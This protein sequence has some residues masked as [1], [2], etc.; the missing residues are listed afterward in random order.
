MFFPPELNTHFSK[1]VLGIV[2]NHETLCIPNSN[3][4][5]KLLYLYNQLSDIFCKY[6]IFTGKSGKSHKAKNSKKQPDSDNTATKQPDSAK[7]KSSFHIPRINP[8]LT[9]DSDDDSI[10]QEPSHFNNSA[11]KF[12]LESNPMVS[13]MLKS[14]KLL[15]PEFHSLCNDFENLML[16]S[17]TKQTWAKHCSAWKLFIEFCNAY[18]VLFE[19]PV[20]K[21]YIRAFVAWATTKKNLKSSTVKAYISSINIAHALGNVDCPNLN[22]DWCTKLALK[23]A[24][25]FSDLT[26]VHRATRLPMNIDLLTLLGHRIKNLEW[27]A[28]AKQVFWTACLTSFFS[29]CRMGE[30][31]APLENSFEPGITLTWENVVFSGKGEVLIFIPFCKTT[32]FNGNLI[33]LYTV[34]NCKFC[35]IASLNRLKRMAIAEDVWKPKNPI[36]AFK[37]G[38]FLTKQKVNLWLSKILSDFTDENHTFTGHSFRAAIPSILASHPDKCRVENIKDWGGWSSD[39]YTVYAKSDREKRRVLFAEIMKCVFPE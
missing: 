2:M 8:I 34:E 33:D 29:S 28:Y 38:K 7:K 4:P 18:G 11:A 32:G 25:N 27:G 26:T 24:K 13:S 37:N 20:N 35:P 22:S 21:E 17:S 14:E 23:G 1:N 10:G 16:H 12:L 30:I 9:G 39:C 19:L 31:L 5:E 6:L 3:T 15:A 36:F